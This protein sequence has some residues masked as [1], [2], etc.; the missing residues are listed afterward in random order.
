MAIKKAPWIQISKGRYIYRG[1]TQIMHTAKAV[2]ITLNA[3]TL[4][5]ALLISQGAKG[6]LSI[7]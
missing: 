5:Y 7:E 6:W 2:Y 3:L 1:T 4:H